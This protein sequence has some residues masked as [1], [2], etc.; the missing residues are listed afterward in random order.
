VGH[1]DFDSAEES[2]LREGAASY[3]L[4]RA[5]LREYEALIFRRCREVVASEQIRISEVTGQTPKDFKEVQQFDAGTQFAALGL[6]TT[7]SGSNQFFALWWERE[8]LYAAVWTGFKDAE[9][10]RRAWNSLQEAYRSESAGANAT[11]IWFRRL[12][13]A[14][15]AGDPWPSMHNC[16]KEWSEA[17]GKIPGGLKQYL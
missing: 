6:R 1:S 8:K 17:W 2:L 10:A 15:E 5:A 14:E 7:G 16:I 12:V 11:E 4:A 13:S 3:R 9:K